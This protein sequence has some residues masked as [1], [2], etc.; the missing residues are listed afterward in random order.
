LVS[1][2]QKGGHQILSVILNT[3]ENTLTASAEESKKLLEWGFANW[4]WQ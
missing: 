4:T 3:N 1:A 2:A